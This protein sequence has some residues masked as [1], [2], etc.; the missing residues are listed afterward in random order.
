MVLVKN[1][2][3]REL[4]VTYNGRS[5]GIPPYGKGG[6]WMSAAAAE[7]GLAQNRRMGTEDPMDPRQFES[8]LYVEGSEMP[9]DAIEQS[10]KIEALDRSL[11][12]PDAQNPQVVTVRRPMSPRDHTPTQG[13]H[14]TGAADNT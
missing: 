12:P 2:T 4:T 1:R 10:D 7:K 9:S 8:L 13:A 14:F 11:L 6:R 3:A 5:V